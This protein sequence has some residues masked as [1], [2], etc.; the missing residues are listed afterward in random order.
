[1]AKGI[2]YLA[3][4][5]ST[6]G[7]AM[8]TPEKGISIMVNFHGIKDYALLLQILQSVTVVESHRKP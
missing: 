6:P 3:Y 5:K 1:M 8:I 7:L 4:D 2:G